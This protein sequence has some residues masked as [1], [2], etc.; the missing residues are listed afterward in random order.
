[1]RS[2]DGRE[3]DGDTSVGLLGDI[4]NIRNLGQM[5]Y[6]FQSYLDPQGL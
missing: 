1:M 3:D 6:P 4:W 2:F 5:L